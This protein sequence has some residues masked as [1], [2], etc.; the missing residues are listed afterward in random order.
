MKKTD[1]FASLALLALLI[2]SCGGIKMYVDKSG[3]SDRAEAIIKDYDPGS[4]ESLEKLVKN[5]RIISRIRPYKDAV[6]VSEPL[7]SWRLKYPDG[8]AVP[9][10]KLSF[11]SC[12]KKSNGEPDTAYFYLYK[13]R[14]SK[15]EKA[16]LWAPG[17][18]VG[19]LAFHFIKAF[20]KTAL[21]QGYDVIFYNIPYHMERVEEG[22]KPGQGLFTANAEK[23]IENTICALCEISTIIKYLR[24]KGVKEIG[25]FGGSIGSSY[26]LIASTVEKMDHLSLMIPILDWNTLI[27]NSAMKIVIDNNIEAGFSPE[28]MK[29]AY[30]IISPMNYEPKK[31]PAERIRIQYA[32]YDRLTPKEK[33][34]EFAEKYN[35]KNIIGYD[36]SHSTI[37]LNRKV[38]EDYRDFLKN[39]NKT[40]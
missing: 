4:P 21:N 5:P 10:E 28:L 23:N 22:K 18:G 11:K 40:E 31:V 9:A 30:D 16:V 36:E 34:F 37:L 19:N 38:Y 12:I 20:F 39:L 24:D 35:I 27:N 26:L 15:G 32:E 1:V 33:N 14:N 7:K 25:G 2:S 6:V 13:S 3:I 29:A 17:L 8:A